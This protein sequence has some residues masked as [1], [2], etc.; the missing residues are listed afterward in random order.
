[1]VRTRSMT[2]EAKLQDPQDVHEPSAHDTSKASEKVS[3]LKTLVIDL[4]V[5]FRKHRKLKKRQISQ[6]QSLRTRN[7]LL[8]SKTRTKKNGPQNPNFWPRL[9]LTLP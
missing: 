7:N 2:A 4:S 8:R 3:W 9:K 1:M 6:N 5:T